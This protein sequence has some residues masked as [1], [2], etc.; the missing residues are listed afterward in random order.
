MNLGYR[1]TAAVVGHGGAEH[2]TVQAFRGHTDHMGA[3][4]VFVQD[5]DDFRCA[6][7][8]AGKHQCSQKLDQSSNTIISAPVA[9]GGGTL[10]QQYDR[11]FI[12]EQIQGYPHANMQIH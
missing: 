9:K 8:N 12:V 6:L 2:Q 3:E 7:D 5:L 1:E 10:S 4:P 11:G